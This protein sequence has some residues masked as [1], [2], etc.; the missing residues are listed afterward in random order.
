[1]PPVHQWP[2]RQFRD[3]QENLVGQEPQDHKE[4]RDLQEDQAFQD[5]MDRMET[6]EKEVKTDIHQ[7]LLF[8]RDK[9][10]NTC[11]YRLKKPI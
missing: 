11:N 2:S 8:L 3:L 5:K 1:M 7:T 6:Q 4:N 10:A 9:L